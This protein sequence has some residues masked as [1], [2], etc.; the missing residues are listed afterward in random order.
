MYNQTEGTLFCAVTAVGATT[1]TS[2][3]YGITAPN[4][5]DGGITAQ[6]TGANFAPAVYASGFE[7]QAVFFTAASRN[8]LVKN[9]IAFRT[10]D[11]ANSFNGN[12]ATDTAGTLVS[13]MDRFVIGANG[14]AGGAAAGNTIFDSIRYYRRRLPNP[15]LQALTA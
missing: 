11:F 15:K 10:D 3:V 7:N 8:V 4:R 1:A 9:A 12:I 2:A 14:N 6:F 5:P 13:I